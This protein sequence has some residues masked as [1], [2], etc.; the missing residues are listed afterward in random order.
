M[1]TI[2]QIIGLFTIAIILTVITEVLRHLLRKSENLKK[3]ITSDAKKLINIHQF[4]HKEGYLLVNNSKK[5]KEEFETLEEAI[6]ECEK[7]RQEFIS[8]SLNDITKLVY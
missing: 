1:E 7:Q 5:T 2:G 4:I 3:Q 6:I 8:E